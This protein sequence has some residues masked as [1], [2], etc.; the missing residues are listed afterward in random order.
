MLHKNY[1]IY[2]S[3]I[4]FSRG[5][6]YAVLFFAAHYLSKYDYGELEYYKKVIEVGSSFFAF[7]FPALILS[8]TKSKE[9]KNY[10]FFLG[11]LFVL[12]LGAIATIFFSFFSWL[13]LI[14]PFVFYAIFFTGGIA[15]SYFLVNQGSSYA[16][17]YKIIISILFYGVVFISIYYFD[18]AGY[19]YVYVNYLLLPLSFIHVVALFHREKILWKKIKRYWRLFRRLLLSSFTLVISNF[20]NMM[21]LYTDIFLIKLLSENSN[22]DIANYSFALNIGNM[23]LLIPLTLVQVDIEKLKN[24]FGYVRE[25]N[26]KIIILVITISVVLVLLFYVITNYYIIDYKNIFSLFMIILSA[27]IVQ[28]FSPI[29]GSMLIIFKRYNVNLYINL[30]TLLLNFILSYLL[31]NSFS[32]YGIA[33][34]S[35]ISLIVRQILLYN[36]YIKS[37]K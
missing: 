10:F 8:Y 4:L 34:A 15:Q 21:F 31:Y 16:S 32:L 19:A 6:E 24:N 2:G 22:I 12:F 20:A 11:I 3:S 33:S 13:F 1:L 9:S 36:S 26:K 27:K 7:G 28:S 23:L 29:Y 5:L 17:Y 30:M 18:V 14:I 25:L 35:V 37:I